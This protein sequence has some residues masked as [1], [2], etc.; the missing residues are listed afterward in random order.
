M[1]NNTSEKK[2][3]LTEAA[4]ITPGQPDVSTVWRWCRIGVNGVRLAY[5]RYGNRMFTTESDL[6]DFARQLAAVDE[7]VPPVA[8]SRK[9]QPRTDRSKKVEAAAAELAESGICRQ[10]N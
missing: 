5:Q 2:L 7:V 8:A 3:S 9:Q 1:S 6:E 10:K 4:A